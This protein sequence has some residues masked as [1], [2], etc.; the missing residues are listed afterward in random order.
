ME[1]KSL[2]DL[3]V[4]QIDLFLKKLFHFFLIVVIYGLLRSLLFRHSVVSGENFI[5]KGYEFFISN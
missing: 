3:L 1:T 4:E 2:C 5:S